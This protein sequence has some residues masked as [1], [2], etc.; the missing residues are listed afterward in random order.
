MSYYDSSEV[1]EL[2]EKID[3]MLDQ[4]SNQDAAQILGVLLLDRCRRMDDNIEPADGPKTNW[5]DVSDCAPLRMVFT[6]QEE[7]R[8]VTLHEL[9]YNA[10]QK[11]CYILDSTNNNDSV[12]FHDTIKK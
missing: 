4:L 5:D 8:F 9:E 2:S 11:L 3:C 1:S 7:T 10:T 6:Q 12:I